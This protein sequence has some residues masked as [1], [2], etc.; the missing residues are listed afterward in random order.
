MFKANWTS[1]LFTHFAVDPAALQPS[2]PY[3]LDTRNGLAYFSLVAFTQGRLRPASTGRLGE[4]L[5][6]PIGSHEFLNLRTYVRRSDHCGIYFISEW[7]PNRLAAFLG[8]RMYGLPYRLGNLQ[9]DCTQ[10]IFSARVGAQSRNLE[11]HAHLENSC[12]KNNARPGTLDHFLLE[13]YVAFTYRNSIGR[14][15]RVGHDPWNYAPVPVDLIDTSLLDEFPWF[16]EAQFIGAHYSPGVFD[17][18]IG[19]PEIDATSAPTALF[20]DPHLF[21]QTARPRVATLPA[22]SEAHAH[23][24]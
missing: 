11:F 18:E 16:A 7:I 5:S 6:R 15:F 22:S 2:I 13:R 9:Y 8:P 24:P 4:F 1:V 23:T 19:P 17:V 3:E 10:N 14:R 20:P 21:P 12:A